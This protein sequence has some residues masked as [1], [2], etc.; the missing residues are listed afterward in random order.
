MGSES[1]DVKEISDLRDSCAVERE[2]KFLMGIISS[3]KEGS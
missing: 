2:M 1:V 3:R